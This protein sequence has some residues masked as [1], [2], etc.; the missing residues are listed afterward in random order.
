MGRP[1]ARVG[2]MHVCPM[3]D[4]PKP[5]VGGPV[6]PPGRPNVLIG[7]LPAATVGNMCTCASAP[8]VIIMGS[9]GVFIGGMPAARMGD[10]T[11]HGGRIVMGLPTVLIGDIGMG[12]I[13]MIAQEMTSGILDTLPP[14]IAKI[15]SQ[16]VALS[17]AA[18]NGTPFVE[19]C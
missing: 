5:H 16:M 10:P 3:F 2:D 19:Q 15:M 4:G 17:Q 11:A 8:D 7:G 18:S 6:L 1:A 12:N 14:N 9:L 13:S